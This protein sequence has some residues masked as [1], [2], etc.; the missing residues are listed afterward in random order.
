MKK[1][2]NK[3]IEINRVSLA[4]KTAKASGV[5]WWE[6]FDPVTKHKI[7][8]TGKLPQRKDKFKSEDYLKSY[9]KDAKQKKKWSRK[10]R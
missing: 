3:L 7:I 8:K 4:K 1:L 10:K 9:G 2:I 5:S 6:F